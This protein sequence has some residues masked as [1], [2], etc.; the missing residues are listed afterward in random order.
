MKTQ[1]VFLTGVEMTAKLGDLGLAKYVKFDITQVY[2]KSEIF[3][4]YLI[5]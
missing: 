5:I 4:N 2:N 1:N 3:V